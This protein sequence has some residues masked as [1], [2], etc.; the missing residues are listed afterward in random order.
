MSK[1]DAVEIDYLKQCTGQATTVFS[2]TP[3]TPYMALY[4]VAPTDSATGTEV[5][6]SSYARVNA[7]AASWAVPSA[8]SVANT[9]AIVFPPVT[10]TGYSVLGV[11][12][13]NASTAGAI[14]RYQAIGSVAIAVADQAQLAIGAAVLTE[15]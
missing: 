14:I 11:A 5:S 15:D 13:T 6:G 2:T 1:T 7:P 8:G 12:V 10:T 4:T 9:S 3:I